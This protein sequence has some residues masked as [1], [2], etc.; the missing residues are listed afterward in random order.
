[1]ELRC[2]FFALIIDTNYHHHV[3]SDSLIRFLCSAVQWMLTSAIISIFRLTCSCCP[4]ANLTGSVTSRQL[5]W[6]GQKAHRTSPQIHST[7][8]ICTGATGHYI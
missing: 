4:A 6:M 2:H 3:R 8:H 7:S 1:M 5:S